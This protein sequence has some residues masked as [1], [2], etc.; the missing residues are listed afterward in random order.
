M[1]IK[2]KYILVSLTV[3][4]FCIG[5]SQTEMNKEDIAM[6]KVQVI[7]NAKNTQSILSD[8]IQEKH[9]S[10]MQ[11]PLISEGKM[12]FKAP[13]LVKWEYTKPYKNIAIF[14]GESLHVLNEGKKDNIDL[15]SNKLFR[16]LNSLIVS[17]IKG[18]M[19]DESQFEFSFY[20]IDDGYMVTF[21]PKD[22]RIKKFI[23]SFEL[24]F[25]TS[26]EVQKVKLIEPN[27]D[28]TW[29]TFKNRRLNQEVS[30]KTFEL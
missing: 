8:F 7:E 22:R 20:K 30:L 12:A 4:S 13:N 18:D 25:S 10:I 14:K 5:F 27:D 6:L 29:I 19:F 17:S 24:Q 16:S 3:L 1:K 23:S 26:A 21:I 11:N 9:L 2:S 28:F 15:S